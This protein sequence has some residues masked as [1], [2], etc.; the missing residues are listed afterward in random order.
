M[1]SFELSSGDVT[2][3]QPDAQNRHEAAES[4]GPWL[5]FLIPFPRY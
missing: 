5:M 2:R 4:C 1:V 3:L